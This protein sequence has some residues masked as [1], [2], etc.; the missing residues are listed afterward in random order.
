MEPTRIA[1][2]VCDGALEIIGELLGPGLSLQAD[3]RT[4]LKHR[5]EDDKSLVEVICRQQVDI[6][7]QML[8]LRLL[9]DHGSRQIMVTNILMPQ[10]MKHQRLGKRAIG[11][12]YSVAE[13]YD[14]EL[15][16]VELVESFF[17]RLVSRGAVVV[18]EQ[19]VK[20]TS[21]TNLT[22]HVEYPLP[23]ASPVHH[24]LDSLL[25]GL[26]PKSKDWSS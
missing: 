12:L 13:A 8:V 24:D 3:A 22:G 19:T 10:S 4:D 23:K 18:D 11:Q 14:Y 7:S 16:V 17:D 15:L 21:Q 1:Q 6:P 9:F 5:P 25:L 2:A 26:T 20:I